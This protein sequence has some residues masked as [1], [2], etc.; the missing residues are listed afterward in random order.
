MDAA[1]DD[2]IGEVDVRND[3]DGECTLQGEAPT[4]LLAGGREVPMLYTHDTN[5][6]ARR[7]VIAVPAGSQVSLRLDW[8]GPFCQTIDGP[9]ELAIEL[10]NDGGTLHV[11]VTSEDQPTCVQGEVINPNARATLSSNVF[12][13]LIPVRAPSSSPLQQLTITVAGPTTATAGSKVTFHVTLHNPTSGPLALDPCPGYMMERFSPGDA[14]NEAV[15]TH[16]LYR[17]NC[18]PIARIP[19]RG[20]A[21]FEMVT[22][23]PAAM[24]VGRPMPGS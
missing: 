6:E 19:A 11:P 12:A 22:E 21:V 3:S 16:Q 2:L 18:R 17:L 10:P 14:T 8:S 7:R 9:R 24:R 13:E 1:I 23:V 20:K 15:N 5:D 4:T